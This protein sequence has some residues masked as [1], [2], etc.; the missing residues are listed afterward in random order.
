MERLFHLPRNQSLSAR[1]RS[2]D[3]G[4]LSEIFGRTILG[5][6]YSYKDAI[7][8]LDIQ[9]G[10]ITA[11]VYGTEPYEVEIEYRAGDVFG[12]C[13][14]PY[15]AACKHLAALLMYLRDETDAEELAEADAKPTI[16]IG[17]GAYASGH[18]DFDKWL[19]SR[20]ER[21]LRDLVR[22]FAPESF[23]RTLAMQQAD[24]DVHKKIFQ[25]TELKIRDL[26]KKADEYGPDDFEEAALKRLEELRPVWLNLPEEVAGLL[27][28]VLSGIDEA[29][30]EGYLYD[31]YADGVFEGDSLGRYMAEFVAALPA[32][33]VEAAAR[34]LTDALGNGDY[35][36]CDNFLPELLSLLSVEK[37]P[38]LKGLLK[39]TNLIHQLDEHKQ[40]TIWQQLQPS[41]DAKERQQILERLSET[42]HAFFVLELA[43]LLESNGDPDAAIKAIERAIPEKAPNTFRY[44]YLPGFADKN[45][46]FEKR[47]ELEQKHRKG[48]KT[49]YWATRYI[50]ETGVPD[51]L[52]CALRYLPEQQTALE[53]LLRTTS[54]AGYAR[55]LEEV[56]RLDEVLTLFRQHPRQLNRITQY[57]FFK[58]H[59]KKYPA[60][61]GLIFKEVLDENL[62]PTGDAAYRAVVEALRHLRD[63]E[64][65]EQFHARVNA[66]KLN[67]K[68]RSNLMA[69]MAREGW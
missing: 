2:L 60:E 23:R 35:S 25:K 67:Y 38:V 9:P 54:V 19:E 29:Q 12:D 51:S 8:E 37:I 13:S 17:G 66:I 64:P 52:R 57:D 48:A 27:E 28:Q 45:K 33:R 41:L 21:E 32:D 69:M 46:L 15:E 20:T 47:L 24:P 59:K 40:R 34:R 26:L 1:I 5:R 53:N 14:C 36:I 10:R 22:Q 49:E 11:E 58:R 42:G 16:E 6:A 18:F 4:A 31:D 62:T 39:T 55:Y 56:G 3:D 61:A 30:N 43:N 44:A 65:L 68:R 7:E 50:R 63:V